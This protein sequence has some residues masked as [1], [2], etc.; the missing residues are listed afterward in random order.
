MLGCW[1]VSKAHGPRGCIIHGQF[2]FSRRIIR[3]LR[4]SLIKE[5]NDPH[6][7]L[8]AHHPLL[9]MPGRKD[10]QQER[11]KKCQELCP[12]LDKVYVSQVEGKSQVIDTFWQWSWLG[13]LFSDSWHICSYINILPHTEGLLWPCLMWQNLLTRT[14]I[15][16]QYC[17]WHQ[18]AD[19]K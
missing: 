17:S 12:I 16:L 3:K 6:H 9:Y 19:P 18:V 5:C 8:K 7:I 13:M 11:Q 2:F 14:L 15:F 10:E 4:K 1:K